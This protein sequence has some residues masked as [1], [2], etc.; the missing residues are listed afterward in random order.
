MMLGLL[1]CIIMQCKW[2]NIIGLND[3]IWFHVERILYFLLFLYCRFDRNVYSTMKPYY[4]KID[5]GMIAIFIIGLFEYIYTVVFTGTDNQVVIENSVYAYIKLLAVYPLLY[6]L[7]FYGYKKVEGVIVLIC[8]S[9]MFYQAIVAVLYNT[10]GIVIST[11]LIANNEW[12]R[13]G[14]I[15]L[16]STCL[17]WVLFILYFCRM[18]NESDFSKKCKDLFLSAFA[19]FFMIFVNQSRSLYVAA[20]A[21]ATSVYLFHERRSK[22]KI[23]AILIL[24]VFVVAFTQSSIYYSFVASFSK[25]GVDDTLTGRLELLTLIQQTSRSSI[26]G[27]GFIGSTIQLFSY[28]FY[29]I[30]Y[31]M[32]G[33]WLQLGIF[34]GTLYLVTCII[35]LQNALKLSKNKGF[36]FDFTIG[37]LGFLFVGMIGFTVLAPARNFAIPII[38]ALSQY[39]AIGN[40]KE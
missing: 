20:I 15:R 22:G 13:N 29:F 25:G 28:I 12:V 9:S 24:F 32:I 18:I 5:L 33:D 27:F 23:V 2:F 17:I 14:N 4:K 38:L 7:V 39:R 11:N 10:L 3:A 21:A 34:A 36:G 37:V 19:I 1:Y 30:D 26:F 40:F 8:A 16:G 35:L 6:L 31:G